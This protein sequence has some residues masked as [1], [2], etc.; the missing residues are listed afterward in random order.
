MAQ[1]QRSAALSHESPALSHESPALSHSVEPSTSRLN[2]KCNAPEL[3]PLVCARALSPRSCPAES[4]IHG[5]RVHFPGAGE[6]FRV[7]QLVSRR[8]RP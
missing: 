1:S 4:R 5:A 8:R 2:S 7:A 3:I 6:F